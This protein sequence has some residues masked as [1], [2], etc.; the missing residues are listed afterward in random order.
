MPVIAFPGKAGVACVAVVVVGAVAGTQGCTTGAPKT[1]DPAA[2]GA[3]PTG[4]GVVAGVGAAGFG[5]GFVTKFGM[6]E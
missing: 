4:G 6:F 3:E 5:A 2:G 1:T